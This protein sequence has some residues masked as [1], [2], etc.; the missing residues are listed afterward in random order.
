MF[1]AEI[2]KN[3][4]TDELHSAAVI[5]RMGNEIV[6]TQEM[7]DIACTLAEENVLDYAQLPFD[8]IKPLKNLP[9]AAIVGNPRY[10]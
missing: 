10:N 3:H 2:N 9:L 4:Y 7:I 6:I 5:D 8:A 1:G